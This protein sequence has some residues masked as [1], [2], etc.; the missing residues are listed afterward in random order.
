MKTTNISV[1]TFETMRENGQAQADVLY[2]VHEK[3]GTVSY[4]VSPD[5]DGFVWYDTADEAIAEHG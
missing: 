5:G 1:S 3:D 4:A 2:K